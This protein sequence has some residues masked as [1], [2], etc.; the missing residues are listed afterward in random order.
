MDPVFATFIAKLFQNSFRSNVV[1][2][3][4]RLTYDNTLDTIVGL[5]YKHVGQKNINGILN[6]G[7]M[8]VFNS[9][10]IALNLLLKL[11]KTWD[12]DIKSRVRRN[13]PAYK[14]VYG[15]IL[16][17]ISL[18]DRMLEVPVIISSLS[19]E[20]E[21]LENSEM[22]FSSWLIDILLNLISFLTA[23]MQGRCRSIFF[24]NIR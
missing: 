17:K 18:G 23:L 9:S 8:D 6:G 2:Q 22:K 19:L 12:Q 3:D 21:K 10:S 14:R 4:F 16:R 5:I 7:R 11:L 13:I 1:K 15:D 20:S 24:V